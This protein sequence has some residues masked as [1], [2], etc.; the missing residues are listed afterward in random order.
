MP[1]GGGDS[2]AAALMCVSEWQQRQD[3][4][5]VNWKARGTDQQCVGLMG[6]TGCQLNRSFP[7]FNW[8]SNVTGP[9]NSYVVT[10]SVFGNLYEEKKNT[11]SIQGKASVI[12]SV[13]PT[14]RHIS[15]W[16]SASVPR[17]RAKWL[18]HLNVG[19]Y[20]MWFRAN[21]YT[22]CLCLVLLLFCWSYCLWKLVL[23][24]INVTPLLIPPW[25]SL[26]NVHNKLTDQ[27][28]I[29]GPEQLL[30]WVWNEK[31]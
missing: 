10:G 31:K 18:L 24:K 25:H 3:G 11:A 7:H 1:G 4:V 19:D 27:Q 30:S 5:C 13:L 8:Q 2:F 12:L 28:C 16:K 23:E 20:V 29:T 22:S 14:L 21:F 15:A 17:S 26:S 9:S 6:F